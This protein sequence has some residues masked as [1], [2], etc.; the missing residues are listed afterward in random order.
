[1]TLRA[2][3]PLVGLS[4]L[5]VAST[6]CRAK[7]KSFAYHVYVEG[8]HAQ[9]EG[10]KLE[11][12]PLKLLDSSPRS[13]SFEAIVPAGE[14]LT[15]KSLTVTL[16]TSCGTSD[17]PATVDVGIT[18]ATDVNSEGYERKRALEDTKKGQPL[19]LTAGALF[20]APREADVY[21]DVDGSPGA[22]VTVG[23]TAVP[24]PTTALPIA[25]IALGTC[26]TAGEV[27]VGGKA[28]GALAVKPR[29]VTG[30]AEPIPGTAF[31]DVQGGHCYEAVPHLY[32][33]ATDSSSP[34]AGDLKKLEGQRVYSLDIDDFLKPSP[35]ELTA[36]ELYPTRTEIRRCVPRLPQAVTTKKKR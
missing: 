18:K 32:K 28:V 35:R 7:P 6:G 36:K 24:A 20:T 26:P 34:D 14:Y 11:G 22:S 13:K 12:R 1:M 4:A 25:R 2:L 3:G 5:L 17:L 15:Q 33:Q 9:V 23:S 27:K 21:L 19:F 10:L 31:V 29:N 8:G 16:T 30:R